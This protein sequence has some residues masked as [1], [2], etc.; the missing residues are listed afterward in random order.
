MIT[1]L[2][3]LTKY[4]HGVQKNVADVPGFFLSHNFWLKTFTTR[5]WFQICSILT[6]H[7]GKIPFLTNIFQVGLKPPTRHFFFLNS[8]VHLAF[9]QQK[10]FQIRF[11]NELQ[12]DSEIQIMQV[13][14]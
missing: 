8:Q 2:N 5:W 4:S 13:G 10:Y 1:P 3:Y 9:S 11:E 7:L 12:V 6:P 14:Y